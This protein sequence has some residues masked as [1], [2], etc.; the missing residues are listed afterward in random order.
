MHE[1]IGKRYVFNYGDFIAINEFFEEE[2]AVEIK[3]GSIQW[4][5]GIIK[6][7]SQEL[8]SRIHLISWREPDGTSAAHVNDFLKMQSYGYFNF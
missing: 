4:Y 6:Y 1:Y 7:S 5:F 8:S 2:V 3:K